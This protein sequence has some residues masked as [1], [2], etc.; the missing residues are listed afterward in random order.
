MTLLK[1]NQV[2]GFDCPG[3]AWP[4]PDPSHRHTAEFCENGAKAVAEEATSAASAGVLRRALV[5]DLDEHTDY[6]LG[7]QGRIT[8]PMVR[9]AGRRPLRAD[10]VG[11]G[12]RGSRDD[13]AR[14]DDP[15]QAVFYTSGRTSNEA[16]FLYQ[17]FV[18]A[19][20][21]N[22]LPDCSN[23]CHESTGVGAR[24]DDRHRQGQ[25]D[26]R[27]RPRRRAHPHRRPEPRH[28]PPADAHARWRSAKRHGAT[29]IA[30]NPL[31]EAG[32]RASQPADP[33]GLSG[34]GH[35]RRPTCSC[36]SGS[37]ATWR[38]FQALGG[39]AGRQGGR[40]PG[41]RRPGRSRPGVH[42]QAHHRVRRVGRPHA[43][44]RLGRRRRRHGLDRSLIEQ[45]A[46]LLA[47]S[48][49]TVTCWAMGITQ[50]RNA[51]A[52]IKEIANLAF[53]AGQHRQAG[54]GHL[55]RARALQRAG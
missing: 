47:T 32:L 15:D 52:T 38:C 29:I 27:R 5:D 17:L 1:L 26:P 16:A 41:G 11:R 20:G 53:A 37:T 21:T 28:Q 55:S 10:R 33:A 48:K 49:R 23:M 30:V 22:N 13:A 25:R 39:A 42:P 35:R 18:R 45:A 46:D 14:L 3:C 8:E 50:H 54:C 43:G 44:A 34:L 9:H 36:R 19:Y 2:D 51:V 7:Q 4:D 12:L 40:R 31:P 6:W 24:R